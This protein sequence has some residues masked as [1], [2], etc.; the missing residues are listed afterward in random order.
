MMA[1]EVSIQK[2]APRSWAAGRQDFD[3]H[4]INEAFAVQALR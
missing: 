2:P 4:E 3:L 1:P